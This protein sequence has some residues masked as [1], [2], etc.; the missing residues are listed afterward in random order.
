M[1]WEPRLSH[2]RDE[3]KGFPYPYQLE[4]IKMPILPEEIPVIVYVEAPAQIL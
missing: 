3:S 1:L 4:E 2:V